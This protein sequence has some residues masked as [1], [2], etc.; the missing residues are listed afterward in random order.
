MLEPRLV[1]LPWD[2]ERLLDS[3]DDRLAAFPGL[4]AWW[5]GVAGVWLKNRSSE[6][7]TLRERLDY[8]RGLS[9]QFPWSEYRVVYTKSGMY[10]AAAI[11]KG[12]SVIDHKLYWAAASSLAE[13]RYVVASLN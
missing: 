5:I 4:A 8:Q 12:D 13:A 1:V 10:L 9:Q 3:G 2:G 7:M 11:V 6:N